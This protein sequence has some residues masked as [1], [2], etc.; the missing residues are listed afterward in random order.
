MKEK[1]RYIAIILAIIPIFGMG[2]FYIGKYKKAFFYMIAPWLIHFISTHLVINEYFYLFSIFLTLLLYIYAIIDIWRSFPIQENDS[3][4][5]SRWYFVLLFFVFY[6]VLTSVYMKLFPKSEEQI[7][8][9]IIPASTMNHT[10]NIGD[11]IVAK[12][13]TDIKRGDI[14]VFR[15]PLSPKTFFIERVVAVGGDEVIYIHKKLYIHFAEG[16]SY[17]HKHYVDKYIKK[18]RDKLWVE[19]PFMINNKNIYYDNSNHESIFRYLLMS[20]INIAMKPIYIDDNKLETYKY[21]NGKN[22]NAFYAK[23]SKNAYFLLGDN[24]ENSNDSRFF[25]EV[26]KKLIYGIATLVYFNISN[27]SR[28]NLAL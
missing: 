11:I 26:D 27:F 18:Y 5:Y 19:N 8:H 10:L 17:I 21:Q 12:K 1:K 25:G 28:W 3:L 14:V 9:F 16:D 13:T 2:Y 22:I 6:F 24:R 4:K 15:Y 23:V 7:Q 20:N